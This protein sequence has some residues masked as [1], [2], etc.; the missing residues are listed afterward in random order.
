[1]SSRINSYSFSHSLIKYTEALARDSIQFFIKD[2]WSKTHSSL[3]T[4]YLVTLSISHQHQMLSTISYS[5]VSSLSYSLS[6][7]LSHFKCVN[8]PVCMCVC[9]CVLVW[10]CVA[11]VIDWDGAVNRSVWSVWGDKGVSI[12]GYQVGVQKRG[13]KI[14]AC[15]PHSAFC[16]HVFSPA[17][18]FMTVFIFLQG[19]RIQVE[20]RCLKKK[21]LFTCVYCLFPDV[22][23]LSAR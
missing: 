1:M 9:L 17:K 18:R 15:K 21:N 5:P 11:A 7:S 13:G 2:T 4:S 12:S 14:R 6:L 23:W 3:Y 19:N 16:F 10:P 8:K 20:D 22:Q